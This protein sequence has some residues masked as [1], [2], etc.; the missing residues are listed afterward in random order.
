MQTTT[1][2]DVSSAGEIASILRGPR[3]KPA[4]LT[5]TNNSL[6]ISVISRPIQETLGRVVPKLDSSAISGHAS[7]RHDLPARAKPTVSEQPCKTCSGTTRHPPK[8]AQGL[9]QTE[10]SGS[11]REQLSE[12]PLGV[13]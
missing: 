10:S 5:S 4:G 12:H 7:I 9:T 6:V 1:A 2:I 3:D 8:S 13:R 11:V